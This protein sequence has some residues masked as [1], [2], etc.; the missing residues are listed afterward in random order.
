MLKVENLNIFIHQA[1]LLTNVNFDIEKGEVIRFVGENGS[2]KTTLIESI[3]NLRKDFKGSIARSFSEEEY[4]YLPQVASQFPKIYLEFKDVCKTEY[5]FYPKSM[6][7]KN[8]HTSS[9]GE[10]KKAL[11]AKAL[12]EASSFAILDDPFNHLDFKSCELVASE[13]MELSRK[14]LTV[15]YIG[16]DY[17]IE[18][19]RD[20]EVGHWKS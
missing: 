5:S 1:K 2:G 14:G 19:T 8:W 13:I 15:L 18:K 9:G 16:H 3:L 11:I 10:R 6:F 12:S 17:K 7:S 4:G 20:I